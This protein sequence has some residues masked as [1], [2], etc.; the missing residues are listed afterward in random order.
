VCVV[1]VGVCWVFLF[2]DVSVLEV[3]LIVQ[4]IDCK[5]DEMSEDERG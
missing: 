2:C 1:A 3:P 4:L 5:W